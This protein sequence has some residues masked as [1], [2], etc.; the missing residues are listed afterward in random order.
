MKTMT[1]KN[2]LF[3][4]LLLFT[5]SFVFLTTETMNTQAKITDTYTDPS[6]DSPRS[7]TDILS[8][9]VNNF[10]VTATFAANVPY[11][12]PEDAG[13]AVYFLNVDLN[14]DGEANESYIA[15]Y[16]NQDEEIEFDGNSITWDLYDLLEE[17]NSSFQITIEAEA[18]YPA[19]DHWPDVGW[20]TISYSEVLSDS[21]SVTI[22]G[23][24]NNSVVS[25]N[26]TINATIESK[27][28]IDTTNITIF[29]AINQVNLTS[30][31]EADVGNN[32][33]SIN[34]TELPDG[35][36][37]ISILV[38]DSLGNEVNLNYQI[39]IDNIEETT[40]T[41]ETSTSTETS[42]TETSTT[43]ESLEPE[44]GSDPTAVAEETTTSEST[45]V[46]ES[47]DNSKGIEET[48]SFSFVIV[49]LSVLTM[50]L[51]RT[52]RQ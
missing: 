10:E 25:G 50:L 2:K 31:V 13:Y 46:E 39:A 38:E 32:S 30:E 4:T 9:T 6:G 20:Q 51:I 35:N 42:S 22:E 11:I 17:E 29:S 41:S 43:S 24:E 12:W 49:L 8:V 1:T 45:S 47:S 28:D 33:W 7:A 26:L 48:P 34:T 37:T 19:D 3:L 44:D 5:F 18:S 15:D 21:L 14:L 40:S 52:K 16:Y 23:F 27:G 36:Y